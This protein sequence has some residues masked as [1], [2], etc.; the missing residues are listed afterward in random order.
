[1]QNT[2]Q[3]RCKDLTAVRCVDLFDVVSPLTSLVTC[4]VAQNQWEPMDRQILHVRYLPRALWA[5][6]MSKC[7][8]VDGR[9][10]A[11]VDGWFIPLL[12]G[13]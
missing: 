8:T 9:N 12:I 11:P 7:H 13:F 10:P 1:M 4:A 5:S 6:V 2:V 3:E